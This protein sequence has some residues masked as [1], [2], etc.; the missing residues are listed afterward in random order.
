[1]SIHSKPDNEGSWMG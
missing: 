1:M